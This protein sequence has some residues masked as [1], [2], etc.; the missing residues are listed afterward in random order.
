MKLLSGSTG[1][2]R[3][4]V[5][6]SNGHFWISSLIKKLFEQTKLIKTDTKIRLPFALR[7][8]NF[9]IVP[10]SV[11]FYLRLTVPSG[12]MCYPRLSPSLFPLRYTLRMKESVEV[13]NSKC[14]L[15][16]SY[17]LVALAR[18]WSY[19]SPTPPSSFESEG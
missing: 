11:L 10:Y 1:I 18:Q 7:A 15:I 9:I 6:P 4:G 13:W 8:I 17:S 19:D 2:S 16:L 12:K 5:L 14:M 3:F